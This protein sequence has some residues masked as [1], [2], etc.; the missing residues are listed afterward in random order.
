[1]K[2]AFTLTEIIVTLSII[3]IIAALTIPAIMKGYRERV[4][5]SQLRKAVSTIENSA[6]TAI[7][8]EH[9]ESFFE[10]T[11]GLREPDTSEGEE[12]CSQGACYFLTNYFKN[13]KIG[14]GAGTCFAS[15]Y[16]TPDGTNAGSHFGYCVLTV[17]GAAI[18][19][20]NSPSAER[21]FL[22][23][24]INGTD[25]PNI[26]GV[27]AYVLEIGSDGSVKDWKNDPDQCNI[28]AED[29]YEHIGKYAQGC[30]QKVMNNNWKVTE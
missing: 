23:I 22:A 1:M 16:K 25:A 27:D 6:K 21:S 3:G 13:S 24:D 29:D 26:T 30:L 14:C 28:E 18:C 5:S 20:W 11:S 19:M 17:S 15:G 10:T 12:A 2:K 7:S 4:Y 9:A 8:D